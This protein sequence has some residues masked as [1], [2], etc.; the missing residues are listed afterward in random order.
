MRKV[1]LKKE[2]VQRETQEIRVVKG[3]LAFS[4]RR[5]PI[6]SVR[7]KVDQNP[8]YLPRGIAHSYMKRNAKHLLGAASDIRTQSVMMTSFIFNARQ[9]VQVT[10]KVERWRDS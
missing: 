9:A 2:H 8:L 4:V 6:V 1:A 7:A 5:V 3:E 10:E